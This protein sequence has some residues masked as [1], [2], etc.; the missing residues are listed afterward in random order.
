MSTITSE[1]YIRAWKNFH[2]SYQALQ[3]MDIEDPEI[4]AKYAEAIT[5]P[6]ALSTS[7]EKWHQSGQTLSS[8]DQVRVNS[9]SR[10][11]TQ[12]RDEFDRRLDAAE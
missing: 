12:L 8:V 3:G 6:E 2:D 1:E 9:Y 10:F 4:A 5:A 7:G 11:G